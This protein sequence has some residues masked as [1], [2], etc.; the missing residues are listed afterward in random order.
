MI[1]KMNQSRQ[2]FL[3]INRKGERLCIKTSLTKT[4]LLEKCGPPV[5]NFLLTCFPVTVVIMQAD[6]RS[7]TFSTLTGTPTKP[8]PIILYIPSGEKGCSAL[9]GSSMRLKPAQ[10][11]LWPPRCPTN[12]GR[13]REN[14]GNSILCT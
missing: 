5:V 12:T 3:M 1:L 2:P 9:T 6:I 4:A 13:R 10:L 8:I 11:G 7:I 14:P